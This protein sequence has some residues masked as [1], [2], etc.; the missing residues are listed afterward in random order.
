MTTYKLD[1]ASMTSLSSKRS[2]LTLW[3]TDGIVESLTL[4]Y[5]SFEVGEGTVSYVKDYDTL[6]T[7]RTWVPLHNL[8]KF[9]LDV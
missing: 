3:Y 7:T 9:R 8:K 1:T 2:T 5:D 6:S 4:A